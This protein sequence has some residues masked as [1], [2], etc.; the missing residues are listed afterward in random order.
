MTNLKLL[1]VAAF[2][3]AIALIVPV[4]VLAAAAPK[5]KV[6]VAYGFAGPGYDGMAHDGAVRAAT[7]FR[8]KLIETVPTKQADLTQ[9]A[10]RS[11]LVLA[12]GFGYQEA[13]DAAAASN[14][15]TS[16]A[17]LDSVPYVASSNLLGTTLAANEGSFLVGAAAAMAST[18]GQVGFIGGMDL[19][20]IFEF[21]AGFVPGVSSQDPSASVAVAYV[22][23]FPDF[24]GF[25]DP[26][27]AYEI[28]MGMYESGID[29]IYHAA[30]NSGIGL[31]EAA[32][33]YSQAHGKV[34][35]IGVDTDQYLEVAGDLQPYILTSMIKRIDVVTYD[36]IASQVQG[37]FTGGIERWD[38]SRNGVN[39]ATSGGFVD[40]MVP[41]LEVLKQ[42]II[43]GLITVP[44]E[45]P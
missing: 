38:L 39:Y 26:A 3:V 37:T 45:L 29:V 35:A 16:F 6:A 40:E 19:P 2:A 23:L 18:T 5:T 15:R 1:R 11:D 20:V 41:V 22:S 9:L 10:T 14:P 25:N 4:A 44:T 7:D 32:R 42:D 33:D 31:F 36:I 30:G 12:V 17:V 43:K 34:W 27:R 24:S 21:Q 13:A 28:A 8:V